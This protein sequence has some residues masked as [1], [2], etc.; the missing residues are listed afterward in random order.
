MLTQLLMPKITLK[1]PK[2]GIQLFVHDLIKIQ[3]LV[4][5]NI[6][7]KC[8]HYKLFDLET[9]S[10][11]STTHLVSFLRCNDNYREVVH[12]GTWQFMTIF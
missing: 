5:I 8:I 12:I 7:K 9:N 2:T 4:L 3:H 11:F 6:T 10:L 1:N